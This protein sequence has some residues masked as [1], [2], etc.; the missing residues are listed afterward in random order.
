MS[1]RSTKDVRIRQRKATLEQGAK[2]ESLRLD[3]WECDSLVKPP[4]SHGRKSVGIWTRQSR[5]F[6]TEFKSVGR[7]A[8]SWER[9]T[10]LETRRNN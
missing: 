9:V 2:I 8:N 5:R 10:N 6:R 7:I 1:G 3:V 4:V